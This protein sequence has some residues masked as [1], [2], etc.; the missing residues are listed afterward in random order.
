M[1]VYCIYN[2]V[3]LIKE[4]VGDIVCLLGW[5]YCVCDYGGIL[6]IDLCDIYG[7]I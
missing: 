6:F 3:V 1:Y 2:C 5:V 4:N 7:V